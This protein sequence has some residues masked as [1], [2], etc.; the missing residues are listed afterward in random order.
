[1]G[2]SAQID[3]LWWNGGSRELDFFLKPFPQF[4]YS[5]YK[6]LLEKEVF[7]SGEMVVKVVF[8]SFRST[9]LVYT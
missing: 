3:L 2:A 9:L 4:L 8:S 1:M 6:K 7:F 5:S